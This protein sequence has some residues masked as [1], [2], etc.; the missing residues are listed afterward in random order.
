MTNAPTQVVLYCQSKNLNFIQ[1]KIFDYSLLTYLLQDLVAAHV[2]SLIF[3]L[4][5]DQTQLHTELQRLAI[6]LPLRL[7]TIFLS[8]K[9]SLWQ[10][11]TSLRSHFRRTF[12]LASAHLLEL[13]FI[14]SQLQTWRGDIVLTSCANRSD[15]IASVK[16][17]RHYVKDILSSQLSGYA[18]IAP[19]MRLSQSFLQSQQV[20]LLA[21][22]S[23]QQCLRGYLQ[24]HV[25]KACLFDRGKSFATTPLALH[26]RLF[27]RLNPSLSPKAHIPDSCVIREPVVIEDQVVLEE[28]CLLQG[29]IY[30]GRNVQVGPYCQLGPNVFITTPQVIPARATIKNCLK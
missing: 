30:L 22:E 7:Q 17:D 9:Y 19:I 13:P 5:P 1:Q 16:V 14:Y 18:P 12:L 21:G 3:L 15:A 26:Q 24:D 25:V 11:L 6:C 28:F 20:A 4:Q 29:P 2:Q 10:N 27:S 23:W 8:P